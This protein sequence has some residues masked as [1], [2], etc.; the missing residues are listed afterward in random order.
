MLRV[1]DMLNAVAGQANVSDSIVDVVIKYGFIP[2]RS[3]RGHPSVWE[4]L[5]AEIKSDV[6]EADGEAFGTEIQRVLARGDQPDRWTVDVWLAEEFF[7]R[8]MEHTGREPKLWHVTSSMGVL[9]VLVNSQRLTEAK[10]D[11]LISEVVRRAIDEEERALSEAERSGDGSAVAEFMDRV[12]DLR[13]FELSLGALRGGVFEEARI[14]YPWRRNSE[15]PRGWSPVWSEGILPNIAPLQRLGILA[16]PV[17][18]DEEMFS[19]DS[20]G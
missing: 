19:F 15:Q 14:V 6:G 12:K 8:H 16:R 1:E 4:R 7:Q 10:I 17:L 5:L 2:L 3:V 9:Q 13:D 20:V 11:L 18:T